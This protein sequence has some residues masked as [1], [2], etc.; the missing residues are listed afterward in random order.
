MPLQNDICEKVRR[1]FDTTTLVCALANLQYCSD[2][3]VRHMRICRSGL[4][5]EFRSFENKSRCRTKTKRACDECAK[6]KTKCN[7]Q[8]PCDRCHRKSIKCEKTRKG[9]QDP[10]A[11]YSTV[12]SSATTPV[13]TETGPDQMNESSFVGCEHPV[14]HL[15]HH[16]VEL[17]PGVIAPS[18]GP[19]PQIAD[20]MCFS[21]TEPSLFQDLSD[22][23]QNT[24]VLMQP[25]SPQI[26]QV[27][28]SA[29]V[30]IE[31]YDVFTEYEL[32]GNHAS[33]ALGLDPVSL[34]LTA[35]G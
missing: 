17:G 24:M 31:H 5:D 11:I 29:A 23:E 22:N 12:T 35:R 13:T 30:F 10:Y 14:K 32:V 1:P 3:F 25:P 8:M 15:I 18:L 9:Y 19:A 16:T 6:A 21:E 27:P 28:D 20:N 2:V 4:S 34:H 26:T 33:F 7:Y